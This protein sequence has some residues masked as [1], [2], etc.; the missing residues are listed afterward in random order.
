LGR[1]GNTGY[2]V[3][4][5]DGTTQVMSISQL[6][7]LGYQFPSGTGLKPAWYEDLLPRR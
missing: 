4:L 1:A 2:N 5:P 7:K 3:Q 6:N